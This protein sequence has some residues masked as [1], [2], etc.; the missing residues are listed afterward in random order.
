MIKFFFGIAILANIST[1]FLGSYAIVFTKDAFKVSETSKADFNCDFC[2]ALITFDKQPLGVQ[3]TNFVKV[4]Y[5]ATTSDA[6]ELA[7]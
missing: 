7:A 5:K 1:E 6:L 2:N 4:L 3:Y